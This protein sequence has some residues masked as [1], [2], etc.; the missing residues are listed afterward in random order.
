MESGGDYDSVVYQSIRMPNY[1]MKTAKDSFEF[2][3]EVR[4]KGFSA[5]SHQQ[6]M[7]YI[8]DTIQSDHPQLKA[9]SH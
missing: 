7:V 6:D 2:E 3:K 9:Q 4:K 1:S 5:E 8:L